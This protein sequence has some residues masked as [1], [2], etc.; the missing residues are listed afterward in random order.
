MSLVPYVLH[1]RHERCQH[2]NQESELIPQTGDEPDQGQRDHSEDCVHNYHSAG[3]T[4]GLLTVLFTDGVNE[5]HSASLLKFLKVALVMLHCYDRVKYAYV[6]LFFL[7]KVHA[8][9]SK[10]LASEVL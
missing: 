4:F 1:S 6:V 8:I 3:L 7:A 9:L 10:R 2:P 5:G